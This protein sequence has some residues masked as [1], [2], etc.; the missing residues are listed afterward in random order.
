MKYEIR[1]TADQVSIVDATGRLRALLSV[2]EGGPSL[3][4]Y[5]AVGKAAGGF[6]FTPAQDRLVLVLVDDRNMPKAALTLLHGETFL[7]DCNRE[8]RPTI[9]HPAHSPMPALGDLVAHRN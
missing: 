2:R 5:D 3:I 7:S 1:T 9:M 4:V 8:G 6:S